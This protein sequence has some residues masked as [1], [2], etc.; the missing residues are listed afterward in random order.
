MQKVEHS[1]TGKTSLM[2]LHG[3]HTIFIWKGIAW[4]LCV[5]VFPV[6]TYSCEFL[7]EFIFNQP[8]TFN[9]GGTTGSGCVAS[10]VLKKGN[11]LCA[12]YNRDYPYACLEIYHVIQTSCDG[13]NLEN[14]TCHVLM[15]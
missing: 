2:N 3:F 15:K 14:L 5:K 10:S 8:E 1:Y 4:K 9:F 12:V 6:Y 13:L 7:K 11:S